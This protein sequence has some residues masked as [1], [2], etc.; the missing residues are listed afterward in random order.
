MAL[1]AGGSALAYATPAS[2]DATQSYLGE[3]MQ[4]GFNFCP[5]GWAQ[6][7]GQILPISQNTALFSLFGTN[8]GGDGRTTFALPNLS[9]RAANTPG[10]GPGLSP[11]SIGE[12]AGSETTTLIPANL[13]PHDHRA[14]LQT[15]NANANSTSANG[16]AIGVSSNNSFQSGTTPSGNLMASSTI[17]VNPTGGSQ[18]VNNRPPYIAL[19]WCVALQGIYPPRN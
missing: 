4:V 12:Q 11:Y 15:A 17:Q 5:L 18:P 7:A 1:A 3:L 13:P 2:A 19:K 9:G 16:N 10:N 8:Y 14:A 6:A